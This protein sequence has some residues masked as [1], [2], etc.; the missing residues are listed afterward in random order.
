MLCSHDVCVAWAHL[1][2][3]NLEL[4]VYVEYTSEM[5][6]PAQMLSQTVGPQ[7]DLLTT[8]RKQELKRHAHVVR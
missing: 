6:M 2:L 1:R 4:D 5:F 3:T 8:A 7:N